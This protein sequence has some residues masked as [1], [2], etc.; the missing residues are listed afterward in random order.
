MIIAI[1]HVED[2]SSEERKVYFSKFPISFCESK[3]IHIG[4]G[5][6]IF[7]YPTF[8]GESLTVTDGIISGVLQTSWGPVYK[9]SAKFDKGVSGGLAVKDDDQCVIGIPTA[10][11]RSIED[12][13]NIKIDGEGLYL[14]PD[15]GEGLG[16]IQSWEM[17]KNTGEIF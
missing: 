11:K 5:V 9:T 4:D 17:I 10:K 12:F 15:F 7:G 6:T 14:G 1:L 13:G 16:L 8:G 2:V 3:N